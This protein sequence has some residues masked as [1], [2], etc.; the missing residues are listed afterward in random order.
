MERRSRKDLGLQSLVHR[1]P[2]QLTGC[3]LDL[4]TLDGALSP[5]CLVLHPRLPSPGASRLYLI[6]SPMK[7]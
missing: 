7:S 6:L 5:P 3:I 4:S 2:T 1:T